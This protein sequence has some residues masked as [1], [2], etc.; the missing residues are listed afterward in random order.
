MAEFWADHREGRRLRS[1]SAGEWGPPA[2][3]AV[4][5]I[6]FASRHWVERH[7]L[8]LRSC[9]CETE[10]GETLRGC[11][12][13]NRAHHGHAGKVAP[14]F[15]ADDVHD[16]PGGRPFI[17]N[18]TIPVFRAIWHRAYLPEGATDGVAIRASDRWRN[19]VIGHPARL[20]DIRKACVARLHASNACGW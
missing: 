14:C 8:D 3:R 4:I 1:H 10:A 2:A 19:V 7:V 18:S 6:F 11:S 12:Y 5:Q 16:A 13:G 15:R 20:A 17:L 9:R